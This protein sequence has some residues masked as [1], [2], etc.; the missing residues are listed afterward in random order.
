MRFRKLSVA[1]HSWL[2]DLDLI[3]ESTPLDQNLDVGKKP[4]NKKIKS[5][6]GKMMSLRSQNPEYSNIP[7]ASTTK[8]DSVRRSGSLWRS[9]VQPFRSTTAIQHRT[10][11]LLRLLKYKPQ[12]PFTKKAR[13]FILSLALCHT[14]VPEVRESG[15]VKF[16]AASPDELALVQAAQ[17][18]GWLVIDRTGK[19]ITLT[20]PEDSDQFNQ[21]KKVYKILNVIEFSSRRKR[22]S[23]IVQFPNGEIFIFCKGADSVISSRLKNSSIA[24]EKKSDIIRKSSL[25]KSMEAEQALRRMSLHVPSA[26]FCRNSLSLSRRRSTGQPL[27]SISSSNFQPIRDELDSWLR[28]RE[29]SPIELSPNISS[30][31]TS[32]PPSTSNTGYSFISSDLAPLRTGQNILDDLIDEKVVLDEAA[33]LDRCFQHIEDFSSEGLRTLLYGHR[34][35]EEEEYASWKKIYVD[36]TTSLLNRQEL[37]EKAGDMIE[38]NFDLTGATAIE[39]KLQKGVPETI[40][41]LRRAN[42]KIW[43]LTGD[44]RETAIN[45]AHSARICKSYSTVIILDQVDGNIQ[46]IMTNNLQSIRNGTN[47]HTVI[48]VDGQTLSE[49]DRN[50]VFAQLFFDLVV[51][52]DSVICCRASPCQKASLVKRVRLKVAKSTTLAIGDGSNDI[53]MI[54][55]AHVGIGI[56]GKEGLQAA[57][58]SDYSIAQFRFLQ[59]LLLVHG[60][61][62]YI[63]TGKYILATFWKE[64][65][66]YLLQAFYQRWAGYTGTSLF[67]STSLTV[68]NTLFTS[69]SV[70]IIGIFEQDLSATT[71]LAVPELYIQG[72][73]DEGFNIRKY[74]SW[75]IMAISESIIIFFTMFGIFGCAIFTRDDNLLSMGTLSFTV[76]LI[77][78]NTKLLYVP[79]FFLF[80][81]CTNFI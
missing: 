62:N 45:I 4:T 15:E 27:S 73:R 64:L 24:M 58:I 76:S 20:Y 42:I 61:W 28:N 50:D 67:E 9:S 21:T 3:R 11:E 35:V 32:F 55:E 68:F 14:C 59:K 72:Q 36:A 44:K 77:F 5:Q 46:Q 47:A 17:D 18:L 34:K 7:T 54:L 81:E 65:V 48:V 38:K 10:E 80:D 78:I 79:I 51:V 74:I 16:Q 66:F 22:M 29:L 63:R 19:S 33:V 23:I 30:A 75:M 1:G 2:H 71:L 6:I 60:R 56:S 26:S 8:S 53:A 52:A 40:D 37:I 49:I 43:M 31:V 57:R 70:I 39:D 41:K 25:R 69:L 13:F 12:S